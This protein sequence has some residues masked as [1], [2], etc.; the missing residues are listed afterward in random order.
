VK[1]NHRLMLND[2]G[3]ATSGHAAPCSRDMRPRGGYLFSQLKLI[4]R[5]VAPGGMTLFGIKKELVSR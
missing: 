5:H 4:P 2:L 3:E 1:G